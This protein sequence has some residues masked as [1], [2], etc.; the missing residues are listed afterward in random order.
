MRL[1]HR[2]WLGEEGE[3]V[4]VYLHGI[5]GHGQW[6]EQTAIRLNHLG[7]TIYALD[8]RGAGRNAEDRGHIKSYRQLLADLTALIGQIGLRH[9]QSPIF[10]LGNCWGAKMA[11]VLAAAEPGA[12]LAGLVLTSPALAVKVDLDLASKLKIAWC[13]LTGSRRRFPIPLSPEMFTDNEP[14]LEFIR[15]DPLRLTEATASFY[16]ESLKLTRLAG[17]AAAR[18]RLPVLILQAGQDRIVDLD[19]VRKWFG[20][21]ASSD[22]TLEIFP[23]AAHSLDFDARAGEYAAVLS[24]WLSARKARV[25]A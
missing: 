15:Q 14:Y 2:L 13:W 4:V 5:E 21:V 10:L 23:W 18:L 19:G 25:A 6:F 22:K 3:P 7:M 8:R 20:R 24:A 1:F 17:D 12:R 11:T 16:V 9:R